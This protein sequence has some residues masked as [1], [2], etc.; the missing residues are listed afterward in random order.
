MENQQEKYNALVLSRLN[1]FNLVGLLDLYK[2][3]GS[4]TEVMRYRANIREVLPDASERLVESL[5]SLDE[6]KQR[7]E[8]EMAFCENHGVSV[9]TYNDPDYPQRMRECVDAP[10]ALFYQGNASLNARRTINIIG[11]RHA[12]PYGVDFIRHFLT[13]LKAVCPDVLVFSGLAYGVDIA[14]HRACLDKGFDTVGVLAHGLD[15]IYPRVH[16]DTAME[17]THHGGLL[18]EYMSH[19][20]AEKL[21]FVRRNRIVAGCS[22]ATLLIE[23][24]E[25]GG[26]LI[27]CDIARTYQRDVFAVPGNVGQPY[28]VGCNRIIRDR[29][30]TLLTSAADLVSAMGWEDAKVEEQTRRK[31]I[32]RTLFPNI[33]PAEQSIIDALAEGGDLSV[34]TLAALTGMTVTQLSSAAFSL[35]MQGIVRPLAG[36]S[37]HLIG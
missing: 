12:T 8:E 18:T 33:T 31:G 2:E 22:D 9:L 6:H 4:A 11:T 35:E 14:A 5:R 26:G 23:S 24:A 7:A 21:N 36:G 25:K 15:E 17:M 27:T 20:R 28:S 10:I 3:L 19:T 30:A 32:Q 37:Y 29:H 34:S 16:R 13:D 1:H